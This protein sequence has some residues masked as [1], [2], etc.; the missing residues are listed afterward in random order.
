M[1]ENPGE[2]TFLE[3]VEAAGQVWVIKGDNAFLFALQID[4]TG[5]SLPVWSGL[6]RV[7]YFLMN[8]GLVGS[9]YLPHAIDLDAFT[10]RWL[11]KMQDINGLLINID[12][13]SADAV[14]L[15]VEEFR[16]CQQ[17]YRMAS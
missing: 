10:E 15:T 5:F 14:M 3:E 8:R 17:I 6:E 13:R 12:G 16:A 9:R 1:S 11:D 7:V 4:D 2:E